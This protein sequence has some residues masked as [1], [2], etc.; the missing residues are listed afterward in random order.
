MARIDLQ[1]VG[2][3]FR[4]RRQGRITL[5]EFLVRRM[6]RQ[7]VNPYIHVHA[8][9][10]V[11]L[12]INDGERIGLIGHNGAGKSTLLKLL[13]GIYPA[14][15]GRAIIEGQISSMLDIGVG[16]EADASGWDNIAYRSYLQGDTPKQMRAKRRDIIEF[17][18]LGDA[19]NMP[20]RFYSSGMMVRLLFSIATA[21]EP[22]VLLV[23][24]ILSAGDLSFQEKA[25]LRMMDVIERAHLMVIASHDLSSLRTLCNRIVWLDRGRVA[26]DDA[27][28]R[29]VPLYEEYMKKG[30]PAPAAAA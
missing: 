4:V 21:V 24:E 10:E 7:S 17:S 20:I 12:Q 3:E 28:D 30:C 23:D 1:N 26:M 11:N 9:Q 6:F 2:L 29:V 13:A 18:E 25:R 16:I 27:P 22:E 5:K 19:I 15:A 8:L 14:T